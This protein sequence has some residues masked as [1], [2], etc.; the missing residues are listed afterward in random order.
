[1]S[2]D[3][4]HDQ[5]NQQYQANLNNNR[6]DPYRGKCPDYLQDS[7]CMYYADGYWSGRHDAKRGRE[8][9]PHDHDESKGYMKELW[10]DGYD[11]GFKDHH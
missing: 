6:G 1:L 5:G 2:S 3:K 9:D 8:H 4:K 7:Q 10:V 11:K